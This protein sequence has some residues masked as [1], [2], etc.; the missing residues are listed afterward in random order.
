MHPRR[1]RPPR[2]GHRLAVL[3]DRARRAGA[4]SRRPAP[5]A[6]AA[7][8]TRSRARRGRQITIVS[9]PTHRTSSEPDANR[10]FHC[11]PSFLHP[12][13]PAV[14]GA[15]APSRWI[16][17]RSGAE[18][19]R[20][21]Y[22]HLGVVLLYALRG[23]SYD[24][25]VRQENGLVVWWILAVGVAIGLFP[26]AG[27]SRPPAPARRAGGVRRSGRPSASPG[28]RAG[29]APSPRSLASLTT[30]ASSPWPAF[31]LDRRTWRCAAA[32]LGAAALF[33]CAL[34]L[35]SRLWPSAFP[36]D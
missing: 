27:P 19:R 25:V 17:A 12:S 8:P 2:A 6:R 21:L 22:S 15:E 3:V 1:L 34:A 30:S 13:A 29:S 5:W 26:R 18:P 14:R 16:R 32:G 11:A 36:T 23:G 28:P 7:W 20:R 33:V 35:A 9:Q 4:P 10:R 24:L 31:L